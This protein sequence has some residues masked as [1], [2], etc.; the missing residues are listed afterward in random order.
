MGLLRT[1]FGKFFGPPSKDRFARLLIDAI[2]RAGETR[3]IAYDA[4]EFRLFVEDQPDRDMPL[5][6]LYSCYRAAS[7][8]ARDAGLKSMVR[9]WFAADKPIPDCFEDASHD[10]MPLIEIRWRQELRLL[11]AETEGVEPASIPYQILGDDFAVVVVYDLP[12]SVRF[13]DQEALDTWGVTFYEAL[14][15]AKENFRLRDH[16]FLGREV[17]DGLYISVT[18]DGYDASR[19]LLLDTIRQFAIKGDCIAMIPSRNMLI[20]TGSEDQAGQEEML[21][22][23]TAELEE[24][25]ALSGIA[26]RLDGDDWTPWLPDAA[27]SVY[28]QFLRLQIPTIGKGYNT[29]KELLDRL[30]EMKRQ[31]VCVPSYLPLQDDDTGKIAACCVWPKDC[32]ALLPRTDQIAFERNEGD[33]IVADWDRVVEVV[34]HLMTPMGIYPE[35]FRVSDF[36][37]EEQLAAIENAKS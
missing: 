13:V 9:C 7:A 1:L 33:A 27:Q 15:V 6:D 26:L 18:Q 29:Q 16:T 37:T 24:P 36:P 4:S 20:V 30:H 19:L 23:A 31:N 2:C 21:R 32:V 12:E 5:G 34:G 14:E 8:D 28:Q 25:F 22:L 17:D 3:K 35:R 10:L 11:L